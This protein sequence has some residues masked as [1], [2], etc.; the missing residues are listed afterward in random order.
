MVALSF[1]HNMPDSS[2]GG[3]TAPSANGSLGLVNR[4]GKQPSLH[5]KIK[6]WVRSNQRLGEEA[7][8]FKGEY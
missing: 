5:Q 2:G 4:N 6:L 8:L 3:A 7:I 1:A